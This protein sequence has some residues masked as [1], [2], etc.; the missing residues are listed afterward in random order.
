MTWTK[1]LASNEVKPHNTS[2]Q[3][4]DKLRMAIA[5][6]LAD[7]ALPG[8]SANRRFVT[9]YNAALQSAKMAIACASYRVTTG[10]GHH[11]I[12]FETSW[13]WAKPQPRTAIILTGAA[14]NET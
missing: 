12:T 10:T 4:L 2:K 11:K 3:E 13:P 8:L 6:D 5:R 14:A 9:A 7:A 1:L